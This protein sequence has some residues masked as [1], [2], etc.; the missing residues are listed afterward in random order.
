MENKLFDEMTIHMI[1]MS[2]NDFAETI[3]TISLRYDIND[4]KGYAADELHKK[5]EEFERMSD[6]EFTEYMLRHML[7]ELFDDGQNN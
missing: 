4:V 2:A 5:V 7:K 3:R 6:H 1:E